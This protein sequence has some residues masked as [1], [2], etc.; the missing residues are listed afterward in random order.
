M[1]LPAT[2]MVPATTMVPATAMVPATTMVPA[3]AI[4]PVTTTHLALVVPAP[5]VPIAANKMVIQIS[6]RSLTL[7]LK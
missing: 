4:V 3:T 5:V 6:V 7:R 2:A 1:P